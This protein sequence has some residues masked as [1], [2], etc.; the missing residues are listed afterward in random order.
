MGVQVPPAH[1]KNMKKLLLKKLLT[2]FFLTYIS[3]SYAEIFFG[4]FIAYIM[5]RVKLH[6]KDFLR[7]KKHKK[8]CLKAETNTKLV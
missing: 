2:V 7:K 8:T 1:H 4:F 3:T 5:R 6:S